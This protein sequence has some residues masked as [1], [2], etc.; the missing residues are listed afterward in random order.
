MSNEFKKKKK[1]NL[2]TVEASVMS[3]VCWLAPDITHFSWYYIVPKNA[4]C[5]Y[6]HPNAPYESFNI[7]SIMWCVTHTNE[8]ATVL[9]CRNYFAQAEK[10][11]TLPN[12]NFF[13]FA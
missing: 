7:S 13:W 3:L 10:H 1:S 12:Q 6:L 2:V 8:A 11:T 4:I 5:E 9:M